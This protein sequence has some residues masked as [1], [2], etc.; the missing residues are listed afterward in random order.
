[1][2]STNKLFDYN[3]KPDFVQPSWSAF[4]TCKLCHATTGKPC[5]RYVWGVRKMWGKTKSVLKLG[6]ILKNPHKGRQKVSMIARPLGTR[7]TW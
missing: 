6:R 3:K 1:M 2:A 5:R 7:I 4:G